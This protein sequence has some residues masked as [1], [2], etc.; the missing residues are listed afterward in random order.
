M[1][2]A[3]IIF[4]NPKGRSATGQVT[5]GIIENIITYD[6]LNDGVPLGTLT[7]TVHPI[8][9]REKILNTKPGNRPKDAPK[10]PFPKKYGDPKTSGLIA[11]ITSGKNE[12]SFELTD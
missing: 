1:E 8:V 12:L 3:E 7:V 2:E 9:D 11:E 5:D 10:P 6:R 4:H